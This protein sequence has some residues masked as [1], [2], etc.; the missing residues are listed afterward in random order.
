MFI[1]NYGI[2]EDYKCNTDVNNKSIPYN[3]TINNATIY[4]VAV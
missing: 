4:Q 1:S 3:D 2:K